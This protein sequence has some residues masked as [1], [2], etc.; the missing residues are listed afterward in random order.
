MSSGFVII[1]KPSGMSSSDVVIKCRNAYSKAIGKKI[2]CG[3]M[4]TLDPMASGILIVAFGNA[5]RL[6]D[7]TLK[8]RKTY[9][10]KFQFGEE[11]DTLD[12]CGE[13]TKTCALPEFQSVVDY[14]PNFIGKIDQVPPKYSAVN[15]NGKIAYDL[16]RKGKD[17]E[18]AAKQVEIKDIKVLDKTLDGELCKDLTL[19]II[20]GGGTYIRS[21]CRDLANG[22]GSAAY[23]SALTRTESVG[24]ELERDAV[25]LQDFLIAPMNYV[26]S[27]KALTDSLMQSVTLSE[28]EYFKIRNG[29][30]VVIDVKDGNYGAIYMDETS[31]ILDVKNKIAKS[32]CFLES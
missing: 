7:F 17:F 16:A 2:K 5:T 19:S 26:R 30:S 28:S 10:A 1:N 20:C 25:E 15:V 13:V 24:F 14:L 27:V 18:I 11:R 3:H 6:F 4:G 9:V 31:F 32:V 8:K 29:Q 21:I 12:A 23:M 22:V